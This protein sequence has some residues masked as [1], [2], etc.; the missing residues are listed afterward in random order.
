MTSRLWAGSHCGAITA[1]SLEQLGT[2]LFWDS[3]VTRLYLTCA[4]HISSTP[5]SP[6]N[7]GL[8][9]LGSGHEPRPVGLSGY[10]R[11]CRQSHLLRDCSA[12]T[13]GKC[14]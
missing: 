11:T 13:V 9:E 2:S 3:E 1:S 4:R 7:R 14:F 10:L 12:C 6:S 5:T 8:W